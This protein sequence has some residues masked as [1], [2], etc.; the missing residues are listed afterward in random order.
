MEGAM[1]KI[2]KSPIISLNVFDSTQSMRSLTNVKG[3]AFYSLTYRKSGIA[4]FNIDGKTFISKKDCITLIPKNKLYSTEILEETH[5][6]AIHFDCLLPDSFSTP[7]VIE[8]NSIQLENLF[9][10]AFEKYSVEDVCNFECYSIFYKMLSEIEGYFRKNHEN[11]IKLKIRK[12]KSEIEK[13]FSDSNFNISTLVEKLQISPSYLRSEFKKAY[14]LSPM[15][16]L[17]TVRKKNAIL[18]LASDYYSIDDVAKL[19]GYC[20]T[21]YF[22]QIFKKNTGYSPLKYKE[23]YLMKN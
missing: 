8:N 9:N 17:S 21:S 4:K 15:E 13:N 5:I 3:R 12:A 6:I 19:C 2:I 10:E 7:F 14:S 18:I 23:K 20:S 1:T 22:I 11:K 16:Y